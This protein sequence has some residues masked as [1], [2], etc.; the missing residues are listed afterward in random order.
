M[1]HIEE[2]D[3]AAAFYVFA[4]LSSFVTGVACILVAR[5]ARG[6]QF[7]KFSYFLAATALGAAVL[8]KMLYPTAVE[9]A[10][11]LAHFEPHEILNVPMGANAT[12]VKRAYRTLSLL[13]HPDKGGDPELFQ[14]ITQ[15]YKALAGDKKS[16]A[17]YQLHGHPDG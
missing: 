2:S 17:N 11:S 10:K 5:A 6:V 1:V 8:S 7:G 3:G 13:A 9:W 16:R 12:V 15:A 4:L 14:L